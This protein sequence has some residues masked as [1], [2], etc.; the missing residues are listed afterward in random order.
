[1]WYSNDFQWAWSESL[2]HM[3]P[4][5]ITLGMVLIF[6]SLWP[7]T[8]VF[9][10]I[11]IT[12]LQR[13]AI[14]NH[15]SYHGR[16]LSTLAYFS[17]IAWPDLIYHSLSVLFVTAPQNWYKWCLW[18]FHWHEWPYLCYTDLYCTAANLMTITHQLILSGFLL[19]HWTPNTTG[20]TAISHH[21]CLTGLITNEHCSEHNHT[22]SK[23]DGLIWYST[24]IIVNALAHLSN[25][26]TPGCYW[27]LFPF[28]H[29]LLDLHHNQLRF[30]SSNQPLA[31]I[32]VTTVTTFRLFWEHC[33]DPCHQQFPPVRQ[34]ARMT[35]LNLSPP[36][37]TTCYRT[38]NRTSTVLVI[39]ILTWLMSLVLN[40][41]VPHCKPDDNHTHW[42]ILS[43]FKQ[44]S[45]ILNTTGLFWA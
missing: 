22:H 32:M 13:S 6:I 23:F 42:L 7:Y 34:V 16:Q 10:L 17:N 28:N 40:G 3:S 1:M 35:W 26:I 30:L 44:P 2:T 24:A 45:G 39:F 33:V 38:V 31:T 18:I 43:D 25:F 12:L 36:F 8:S 14:G 21:P 11:P 27:I 9:A 19:P 5:I 4:L 41:L 37:Y 20:L 15:N 29:T